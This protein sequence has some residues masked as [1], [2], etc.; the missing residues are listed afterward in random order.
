MYP[1]QPPVAPQSP[2][3]SPEYLNQIAPQAP[4][5]MPFKFGP[6]LLIIIAAILVVLIIIASVTVNTLVGS[7]RQPLQQLAARLTTT[8]TIASDAQP[9]L[10]SS[11]LRSLNSNLKIYLT[12]TNRDIG[13]PLLSSGVNTTK[14][15]ESVLK[16]ESGEA[17]SANLEDAR[18]NAVFDRT[19]ARE[20]TYI[21]GNTLALMK[22]ARTSTGSTEL[23]E[24]LDPA[25]ADLTLIHES[26]SSFDAAGN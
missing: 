25:I 6:K 19:Y 9:N 26:F 1:E 21:L 12:N 16:K 20:M 17:I 5:A 14:L 13:Q 3:P 4:K 2:A 11:Q 7:Q 18:L 22:Q 23:R 8:E 24:F 10:K 15:P